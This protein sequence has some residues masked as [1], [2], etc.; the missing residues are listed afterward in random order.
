[1]FLIYKKK[2]CMK[3]IKN[4]EEISVRNIKWFFPLFLNKKIL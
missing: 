2:Y 3:K 1:M 4:K